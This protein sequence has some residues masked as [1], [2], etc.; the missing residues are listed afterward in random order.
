MIA[1]WSACVGT[2]DSPVR[3]GRNSTVSPGTEKLPMPS[4]GLSCGFLLRF[5]HTRHAP[6]QLR[7][8]AKPLRRRRA[9]VVSS[10]E[11]TR[12]RHNFHHAFQPASGVNHARYFRSR[13]VV[14]H[15]QEW[16]SRLVIIF[17]GHRAGQ[18]VLQNILH[19]GKQFR[20]LRQVNRELGHRLPIRQRFMA[21]DKKCRAAFH[22]S[23]GQ[24]APRLI[25]SGSELKRSALAIENLPV[26]QMMSLVRKKLDH[27]RR[28][29]VRRFSGR[30][31]PATAE[32]VKIKSIFDGGSTRASA[33][34]HIKFRRE[35]NL[36]RK[37]FAGER[38]RISDRSIAAQLLEPRL[39]QWQV[40]PPHSSDG[41]TSC[42]S[43]S[44]PLSA[45]VPASVGFT[46]AIFRAQAACR[47]LRYCSIVTRREMFCC[48][49]TSSV[50]GRAIRRSNSC[51]EALPAA[52]DCRKCSIASASV[53]SGVC[54]ASACG[55]TRLAPKA[56]SQRP[57]V[58]RHF[59]QSHITKSTEQHQ[60]LFP[61]GQSVQSGTRMLKL[62]RL[63]S[64]VSSAVKRTLAGN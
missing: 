15:S 5:P 27:L 37:I 56:S 10:E 2:G 53:K 38:K 34:H 48:S 6:A 43:P 29:R 57:A 36:L 11:L 4:P 39:E 20:N 8:E 55:L 1:P 33:Q 62:R 28:R 24:E 22:Q 13:S 63:C 61:G 17:A 30:S 49:N 31:A 44:T 23:R 42:V 60:D 16:G 51:G 58:S 47:T 64:S 19:R 45:R 25:L 46:T 26:A 14:A 3:L 9:V 21:I 35:R 54:C 59:P 40:V 41:A 32:N 12:V 18:R 52:Q 50:P 7:I